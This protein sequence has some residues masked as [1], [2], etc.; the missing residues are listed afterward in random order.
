MSGLK[1]MTALYRNRGYSWGQANRVTPLR[2]EQLRANSQGKPCLQQEVSSRG[3]LTLDHSRRKQE[4]G[5][6]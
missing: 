1:V 2:T 4:E 3:E 6:V 5:R